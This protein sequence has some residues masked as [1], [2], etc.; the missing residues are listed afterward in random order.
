MTNRADSDVAKRTST[1]LWASPR[2]PPTPNSRRP[3]AKRRCNAT[4]TATGDHQAETRFKELNEAYQTLSDANKRSAYDRYGH[5]A[6][7]QNGAGMGDASLRRWPTIFDDCSANIW[8][9]A[10]AAQRFG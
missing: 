6:F 9:G 4:P 2:P 3:S 5:A 1:R 10:A 7:E 8:A